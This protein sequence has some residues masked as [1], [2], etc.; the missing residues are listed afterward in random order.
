[1]GSPLGGG[2]TTSDHPRWD[3]HGTQYGTDDYDFSGIPGGRRKGGNGVFELMG[4]TGCLWST[5]LHADG[6]AHPLRLTYYQGSVSYFQDHKKIGY[7]VRCLK[8]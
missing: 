8:D 5:T 2:C 7:S 3:Y 4:H 6:R 1:V